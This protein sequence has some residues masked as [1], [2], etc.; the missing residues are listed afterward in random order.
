MV[1]TLRV[2]PRFDLSK[3][4]KTYCS[5]I[6]NAVVAYG[7]NCHNKQFDLKRE[8][9]K[10]GWAISSCQSKLL[11]FVCI[12]W[13]VVLKRTVLKRTVVIAHEMIGFQNR[14]TRRQVI[15]SLTWKKFSNL[16]NTLYF[17]WTIKARL[18]RL[19]LITEI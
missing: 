2:R 1:S 8:I 18:F 3:I 16:F 9:F 19:N 7:W 14:N 12:Q 4:L 15:K 6:I 10:E 5:K 17:R 11:W 13:D